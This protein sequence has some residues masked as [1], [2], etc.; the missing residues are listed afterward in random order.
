MDTA[1]APDG[2]VHQ[3]A[4]KAATR[5]GLLASGW[6]REVTDLQRLGLVIFCPDCER[7]V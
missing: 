7:P 4:D 1:T 5:C 3:L 6:S 2:V